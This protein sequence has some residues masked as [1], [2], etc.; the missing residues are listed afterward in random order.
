MDIRSPRTTPTSLPM[1]AI[2]SPLMIPTASPRTITSLPTTISL[3]T[4]I[5]HHMITN[6]LTKSHRMI[7]NPVTIISHP[8]LPTRATS[9]LMTHVSY[10]ERS[11]GTAVF[12][13]VYG[14]STGWKTSR[15]SGADLFQA[16]TMVMPQDFAIFALVLLSTASLLV[17]HANR[18]QMQ[19]RTGEIYGHG[20]MSR[21]PVL[22]DDGKSFAP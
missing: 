1:T 7:T 14:S 6:R 5:S 12:Y 11:P 22:P 21:W 8:T 20:S 4:T 18:P 9:H 13:S 10:N 17:L 16:I 3:H 2:A 19:N 15:T